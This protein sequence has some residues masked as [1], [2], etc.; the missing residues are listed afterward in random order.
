MGDWENGMKRFQEEQRA[1][2]QDKQDRQELHQ[3]A[4]SLLVSCTNG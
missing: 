1:E 3:R 4:A 2:A